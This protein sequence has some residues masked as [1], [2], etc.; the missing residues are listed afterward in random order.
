M[1]VLVENK[2]ILTDKHVGIG[3]I[4]S[5]NHAATIIDAVN[6]T[7][8]A[9]VYP[10]YNPFYVPEQSSTL[11]Y[12]TTN[13]DDLLAMD[14]V[15]ILSPNDTHMHY[16]EKLLAANYKGYIFCEK[17]PVTNV[18]E[19]K[20]LRDLS[21]SRVM[22]D[23][24]L[25]YSSFTHQLKD[26]IDQVGTVIAVDAWVTHGLAFKQS[27]PGSWRADK[28]RHEY[29]VLETVSVHWIDLFLM[30]FGN[31]VGTNHYQRNVAGTGSSADTCITRIRH[32]SGVHSSI[33]S[34]Y[35][36]PASTRLL[37]TGS[38]GIIEFNDGVMSLRRPRDSFDELGKFK[39]PPI[40]ALNSVPDPFVD[41]LRSAVNAFVE[42][43]KRK[44]DFPKEWIKH[45]IETMD[46]IVE[47]KGLII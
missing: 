22:Y 17:P 31:A 24:S 10:I 43:I 28:L 6:S 26:L 42:T 21:P 27:Y 18:V 35:A 32:A 15:M 41:G 39:N 11:S 46:V 19:L 20:K 38:D 25:R 16:L 34:S 1:Y 7:A 14:G 23:F 40:A 33:V 37:I 3:A 30:L 12:C 47:C 4:G 36:A 45:S 29:G 9:H 8:I 5:C 44:D 13:F 2:E